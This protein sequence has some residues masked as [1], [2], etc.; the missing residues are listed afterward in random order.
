MGK[1]VPLLESG[2]DRNKRQEVEGSREAAPVSILVKAVAEFPAVVLPHSCSLRSLLVMNCLSPSTLWILAKT[3]VL[4]EL[5]S[6]TVP[7]Q[8]GPF[9]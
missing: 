6:V 1:D 8:A 5:P 4:K 7:S 3:N 2:A 9:N